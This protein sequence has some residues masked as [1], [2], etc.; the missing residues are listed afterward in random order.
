MGAGQFLLGVRRLD[1]APVPIWYD[2]NAIIIGMRTTVQMDQAGRVVLPKRLRERFRLRGGD[3]LVL[4]VTGDAIQLRPQRSH[5]RLERVNGVLV[6]VIEAP[7]L[8]GRDLVAESRDER[9]GEIARG[10]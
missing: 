8:E 2:I 9:I 1:G 3:L 10:T 5:V 6:L 7:S 4:E